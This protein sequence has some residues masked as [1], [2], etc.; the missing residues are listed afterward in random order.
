LSHANF[1]TFAREC[2]KFFTLKPL[3]E[4]YLLKVVKIIGDK[5]LTAEQTKKK[6]KPQIFADKRG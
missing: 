1:Q 3:D 5:K 2:E 4:S 6:T